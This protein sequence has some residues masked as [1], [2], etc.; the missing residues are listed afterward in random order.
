VLIKPYRVSSC[1]IARRLLSTVPVAFHYIEP[2]AGCLAA[3]QPLHSL[4]ARSSEHASPE[5]PPRH[6]AS[7]HW[8]SRKRSV[9]DTVEVCYY[10]FSLTAVVGTPSVTVE[11]GSV[12]T[13]VDGR[14]LIGGVAALV[15]GVVAEAVPADFAALGIAVES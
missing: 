6:Q 2:L 3:D 12:S 8:W 10:H 4:L 13:S 5:Y 15:A 1:Q 14:W 7:F 11:E 9:C